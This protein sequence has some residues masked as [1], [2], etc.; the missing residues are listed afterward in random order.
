MGK[1]SWQ[2]YSID[3]DIYITYVRVWLQ[4]FLHFRVEHSI[5]RLW[6]YAGLQE[7]TT[8]MANSNLGTRPPTDPP[9]HHRYFSSLNPRRLSRSTSSSSRKDPCWPVK[10]NETSAGLRYRWIY[11]SCSTLIDTLVRCFV[12][13]FGS[14]YQGSKDPRRWMVLR[15]ATPAD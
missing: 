9:K 1:Q 10:D 4:R 2:V 12:V 14:A 8:A 6:R 15:S 5:I 11:A 7:R 3:Q 13:N